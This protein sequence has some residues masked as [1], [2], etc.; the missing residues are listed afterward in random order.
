MYQTIFRCKTMS[1]CRLPN[2]HDTYLYTHCLPIPLSV[3]LEL[4]SLNSRQAAPVFLYQFC[5]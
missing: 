1:L 5:S 2:L 4:I 3:S